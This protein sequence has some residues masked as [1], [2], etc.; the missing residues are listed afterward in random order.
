MSIKIPNPHVYV[1][2]D[3]DIPIY[4][5]MYIGRKKLVFRHGGLRQ[6]MF[7]YDTRVW[8]GVRL[9]NAVDMAFKTSLHGY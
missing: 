4:I 2:T 7:E 1:Y 3:I 8:R 5:D 9:R 6:I